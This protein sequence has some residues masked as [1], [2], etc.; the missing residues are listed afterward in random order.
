VKGMDDSQFYY[1]YEKFPTNIEGVQDGI[2]NASKT[3][4][5]EDSETITANE[6]IYDFTRSSYDS[7]NDQE[8]VLPLISLIMV[9]MS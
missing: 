9:V 6:S 1:C 4:V 5:M 3:P 2:H 8:L 7:K